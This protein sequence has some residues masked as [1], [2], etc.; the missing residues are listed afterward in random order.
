MPDRDAC[1]RVVSDLSGMLRAQPVAV[2]DSG[3]GVQPYW[4]LEA[5]DVH[6]A[7]RLVARFR[8]L[9]ELVAGENGGTV[10]NV[11]DVSRILRVPGSVNVKDPGSPVSAV[12]DHLDTDA[13]VVTLDGL[14]D[15]LLSYGI[16]DVPATPDA[17]PGATLVDYSGPTYGALEPGVRSRVDAWADAPLR[18]HLAALD[19]CREAKVD[20]W[21]P[22]MPGPAWND[23]LWRACCRLAEVAVAPWSGLG[24]E[25]VGRL[26]L[27]HAPR[28]ARFTDAFVRTTW[29]RAVEHVAAKPVIAAP[30][31]LEPGGALVEVDFWQERESL[32]TIHGW[33]RA[34]MASPWAVLGV[35]LARVITTVPP[36]VVLPPTIGSQASLNLF[37]ALVAASGG[38][39]GAATGAARD[40]VVVSGE[41]Y[42]REAGSGEGLVKQ[43]ATRTKGGVERLRDAVLF[44]ISEVDTLASMSA[45]Q[46]SNLLPVMRKAWS[47][48]RLGFAY[49]DP[50]KDIPLDPHTYRLCAVVGVQPERA[51]GLFAEAD[52]GTPQRFVWLSAVDPTIPDAEP[53][54]PEPWVV[55]EQRWPSDFGGRH[56][57]VVPQVAV[58]TIKAAHRARQRGEA[59]ALDGHALL[60]RAK[61]MVALTLLDGRRVPTEDDWR[62]SGVVMDESDRCRTGI[63][64]ALSKVAERSVVS[65]GRSDGV[66]AAVAEDAQHEARLKRVK[67]AVLSKLLPE[68]Q[69]V[70]KVRKTLAS[71]DRAAFDDA[72]ALLVNALDA[73]VND[74]KVRN[75]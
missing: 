57:L 75:R 20:G 8:W 16:R 71:R 44:D 47:G 73:E 10:D 1:D 45:R 14:S 28:D 4:R 31:E 46:G 29:L 66:R 9:V 6:V 21:R 32:R 3:H 56:E 15:V 30:L 70:G 11:F 33:A 34:R 39:K 35:A 72:L 27:E 50:T 18:E 17:G 59:K 7:A 2:V 26:V 5:G 48:E 52:G 38:G 25:D 51:G 13:E 69:P 63:E 54:A 12:L 58:D 41:V 36:H 49:A 23:T 60:C 67:D 65:R 53:D 43:Y 64:E 42:E 62:L 37:F 68:W 19:A 61:V 40:A 74:G 55:S 22:G 24:L